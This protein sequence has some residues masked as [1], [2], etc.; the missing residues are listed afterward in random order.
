MTKN[1]K[2]VVSKNARQQEERQQEQVDKVD[3]DTQ[4]IFESETNASDT[5]TEAND[6][7]SESETGVNEEENSSD[8]D[9]NE[10]GGSE[11]DSESGTERKNTTVARRP[12]SPHSASLSES[13]S[14]TSASSSAGAPTQASV[15][16]LASNPAST[17]TSAPLATSSATVVKKPAVTVSSITKKDT[18]INNNNTKETKEVVKKTEKKSSTA[19][20]SKNPK[21]RRTRIRNHYKISFSSYIYKV[22]MQVHTRDISISSKAMST[23]NDFCIDI[24]ERLASEASS[25]AA[26]T[27]KKTI[28]DWEIQIASKMILPGGLATHAIAEGQK[29]LALYKESTAGEE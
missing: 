10:E 28:T 19:P 22:L 8:E 29:A 24:F 23:M 7:A 6:S 20:P 2:Q 9:S 3:D 11:S 5:V 25:L 18:K 27:H 12:P 14:D 21:A 1:K 16:T 4:P 13:S 15:P 17:P 26:R